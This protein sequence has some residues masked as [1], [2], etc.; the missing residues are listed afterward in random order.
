MILKFDIYQLDIDVD[1]TQYFYENAVCES[2][3]LCSCAG[4]RNF[5]KSISVFP[6]KVQQ[7][8]RQLGI[9]IG[10]P[11]EISAI[12]SPDGNMTLYN[13]FY[14][15]C[16]SI[17]AGKN[18]WVQVGA[19]SFRLDEQYLLKITPDFSVYFT[20]KCGLV[21]ED[22][23]APVIQL[24]VQCCIPWVLDEPNPY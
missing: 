9:D 11:A 1:R 15:I 7:F 3:N 2:S 13:G 16:G 22:F 8:F 17:L 19:R 20:D 21:D 24:E 12:H 14:H 6:E 10:K 23:P 5:Y 4:C 18:P